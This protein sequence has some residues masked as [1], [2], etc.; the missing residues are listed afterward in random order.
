[1]LP[2]W[3]M[4]PQMRT[5]MMIITMHYS[6]SPLT[7]ITFIDEENGHFR[8]AEA[9]NT[10][11]AK[12]WS[13]PICMMASH[14]A[15]QKLRHRPWIMMAC[16]LWLHLTGITLISGDWVVK[17]DSWR[18]A[19][20]TGSSISVMQVCGNHKMDIPT[21]CMMQGVGWYVI[22]CNVITG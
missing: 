20:T 15:C 22:W 1:M 19:E 16:C 4:H 13:W 9:K 5:S 14:R 10:L 17:N 2:P 8:L 3:M 6:W 18:I 7:S 21:I 11:S 12:E